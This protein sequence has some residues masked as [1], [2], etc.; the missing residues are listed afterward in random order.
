MKTALCETLN[1]DIPIVQAPIGGPAV[2]RL[3]A[4]VSSAGGMGSI[5]MTGRGAKIAQQYI[6]EVRAL[7]DNPF[8]AGFL[9]S[10]PYEDELKICLEAQIPVI[11]FFW[12]NPAHLIDRVHDSGALAILSV[13]S[14]E[15]ARRAA[16]MGIDII[17]AQ[18][19]EAG[20]H[21]RGQVATLALVP[22]VVDAASP[23]PVI[24][25]RG[26]ADGRGLA[27]ALA[28]GAVGGW[29]GTRFLASEEAAVHPEY[30]Q[31]VVNASASDTYYTSMFDVGWPDAPARVIRNSTVNAWENANRPPTGERPNEGDI[32]ATD[33]NGY[34][35][36]RYQPVAATPD[37]QGDIEA[38]PLWA[39]QCVSQV[40]EV[41]SAA[42]IIEEMNQE[43]ETIL[44]D[45]AGS[46][47]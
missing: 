4:A 41:R 21:V 35:V 2:P 20:G 42:Q 25:A 18:G 36:L 31:S 5:A 44:R 15:E 38:F 45:L 46:A 22:T 6:N 8:A 16:D 47:R 39:G 34:E 27:A 3:A 13:G 7:T 28:L 19:W 24:A 26:I 29:I 11:S 37:Y 33:K 32:L 1:I 30:Q 9:L 40:E 12:G 17:V 14:V 43:A 10:Y 23:T